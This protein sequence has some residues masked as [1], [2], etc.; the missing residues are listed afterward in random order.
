MSHQVTAGTD[1]SSV[2]ESHIRLNTR[3][4]VEPRSH[5]VAID[6]WYLRVLDHGPCGSTGVHG[7]T[8]PAAVQSPIRSVIAAVT[9]RLVC[10]TDLYSLLSTVR[11]YTSLLESRNLLQTATLVFPRPIVC[12]RLSSNINILAKKNFSGRQRGRGLMAPGPPGSATGQSTMSRL[13]SDQLE[14]SCLSVFDRSLV[15]N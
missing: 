5:T 3:Y 6:D 13:S 12:S 2:T 10:T 7:W 8:H 11:G 9:T 4:T 14:A 1:Q 15:T